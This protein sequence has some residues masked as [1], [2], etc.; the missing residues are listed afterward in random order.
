MAGSAG[1]SLGLSANNFIESALKILATFVNAK[2]PSGFLEP[3]G[4][5][6]VSQLCF[7]LR[8]CFFGAPAFAIWR[9]LAN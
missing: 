8:L 1:S 9:S 2:L 5:F 6:F 4:L 3:L 7:G